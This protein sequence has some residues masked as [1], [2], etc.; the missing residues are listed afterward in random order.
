MDYYVILGLRRGA[1]EGEIKRAYRRLARR[2]HPD[3]NPGDEAA[4][5]LFRRIAEAYETLMDP[6]R[7]RL[8]DTGSRQVQ[9]EEAALSFDG[10][11]F[12]VV[13]D[14]R[15]GATFSELFADVFQRSAGIDD[16]RPQRGADIHAVVSLSFEESVRGAE[17]QMTVTRQESCEVCEGRGTVRTAEGQCLQCHGSGSIRWTRGHM[18][19]SRAC[20]SCG[21]T[22]RRRELTCASCAGQGTTVRTEPVVVRIPAGIATGARVRVAG[23]GHAGRHG[24]AVGDLVVTVTVA[25]HP[26]FRRQG[27]DL[28]LTV[29]VALH[30]ATLGAK[31]DV[32]T[33]DGTAKLRVPPGTQPGQR[34]RLR[35][36]GVTTEE[37]RTGDLVIDIRVVV[38]QLRDERSK[39]LMR[40]FARLNSDNVRNDL[41]V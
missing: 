5:L 22:G 39:E 21:G 1:T 3:I 31:V 41:G 7:R 8:Y 34:F 9:D 23:K 24:G 15:T 37:G 19:F 35:G 17:R 4:G 27:D 18:V 10:F 11:D 2:Y 30:E 16:S 13:T 20:T 40:E 29:P 25:E 12:S 38:P 33:P 32:P 6:Q 26:L 28:L 14:S 36:R